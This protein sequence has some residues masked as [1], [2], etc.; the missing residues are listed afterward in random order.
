MGMSLSSSMDHAG[1]F[2]CHTISL[3]P[4]LAT[5]ISCP[6][7][8]LHSFCI[9]CRLAHGCDDSLHCR[10]IEYFWMEPG[11]FFPNNL[12]IDP[13]CGGLWY[14]IAGLAKTKAAFL[15]P[16]S[17]LG[18]VWF[19]CSLRSATENSSS[20]PG[21]FIDRFLFYSITQIL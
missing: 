20:D 17:G 12:G 18:I 9:V 15:Y 19:F 13:I 3:G 11:A 2:N 21:S 4:G 8:S 6:K 14:C 16:A 7:I 1:D 5:I 10:F